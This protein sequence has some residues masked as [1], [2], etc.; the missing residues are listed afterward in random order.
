MASA[1]VIIAIVFIPIY[2]ILA[3]FSLALA[4][5]D[6]FKREA[7]FLPLLI[8]SVVRCVGNILMVYVYYAKSTSSGLYIAA[9]L[10]QGLGYSFL[11]VSGLS[12]LIRLV[13]PA[14]ESHESHGASGLLGS[15]FAR[16][17][18]LL[19]TASL[20]GLIVLIVGYTQSPLFDNLSASEMAGT[21][22]AGGYSTEVKAGDVIFIVVTVGFILLNLVQMFSLGEGK[23]IKLSCVLLLAS[24]FML[25]SAIYSTITAFSS[26]PL[27]VNVW[28][29]LV[30]LQISQALAAFVL[31]FFGLIMRRN[32]PTTSESDKNAPAPYAA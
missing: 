7:G 26:N 9:Y 6:G 19:Q 3:L 1:S 24:A 16:P 23:S 13:S 4:V 27:G 18:R 28:I 11:V 12:L 8:F 14:H 30:F 15:G 25:A 20:V 31:L 29:K 10:L 22:S 32:P 17:V 5:R 2:L 21:S